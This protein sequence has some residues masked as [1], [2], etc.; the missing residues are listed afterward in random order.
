MGVT[1]GYIILHNDADEIQS[2]HD[3]NELLNQQASTSAWGNKE[4]WKFYRDAS[5]KQLPRHGLWLS[6]G[7]CRNDVALISHKSSL[8]MERNCPV[9]SYRYAYT[10][11]ND[12]HCLQR[13]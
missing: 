12:Y 10:A 13:S 2:A 9:M 4:G 11:L 3:D 5:K 6:M 7:A 8:V 1:D